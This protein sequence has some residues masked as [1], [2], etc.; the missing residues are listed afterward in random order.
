M[1]GLPKSNIDLYII[2]KVKKLRT[3]HKISQA[4]LATKLD[5]SDAF[6]GQIENPKH[7]S[8]YS[9][10]QLNKLAKIFNCSPRDFLPE[11]PL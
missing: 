10:V 3:E 1:R 4:V 6:I 7:T 2:E 8:K 5:V 9:M 11:K